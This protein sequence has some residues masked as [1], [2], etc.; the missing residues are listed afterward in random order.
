MMSPLPVE[1]MKRYALCECCNGCTTIMARLH[2]NELEPAPC[3]TS[4]AFG[5]WNDHQTSSYWMW[6]LEYASFRPLTTTYSRGPLKR[7]ENL[8]CWR[9]ASSSSVEKTRA[10]AIF[11]WRRSL[12]NF[13]AKT[14]S[15]IN[16]DLF[17]PVNRRKGPLSA[18]N[19]S[20]LGRL[21]CRKLCFHLLKP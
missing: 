1:I 6:H 11:H 18:V 3:I 16:S 15:A 21:N 20:F 5:I 12:F 19:W 7:A 10:W 14:F 4:P 9:L 2:S 13:Q 8:L 17:N